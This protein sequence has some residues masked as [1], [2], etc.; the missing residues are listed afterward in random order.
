MRPRGDTELSECARRFQSCR[1]QWI[2]EAGEQ[3]GNLIRETIGADPDA[4]HL[5]RI[6]VGVLERTD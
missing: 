2:V 3:I 4:G 1:T 5:P 6:P